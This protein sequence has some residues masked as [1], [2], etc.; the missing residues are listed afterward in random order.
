MSKVQDSS[1]SCKKDWDMEDA[2][3]SHDKSQKIHI[4]INK[5]S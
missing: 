1:K 5:K 2:I 4:H 3:Y